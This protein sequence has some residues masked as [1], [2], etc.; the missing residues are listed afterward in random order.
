MPRIKKNENFQNCLLNRRSPA[1]CWKV[2]RPNP[3]PLNLQN[4]AAVANLPL[5]LNWIC[6]CWEVSWHPLIEKYY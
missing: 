6:H 1:S 4:Q 2:D 3:H 5:I